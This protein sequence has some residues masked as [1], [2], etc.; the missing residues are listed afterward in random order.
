VFWKSSSQGWLGIDWGT[1]TIKFAQL[2]RTSAG[3]RLARKVLVRRSCPL[4]GE[5]PSLAQW[6]CDD[7]PMGILREGLFHRQGAAC[8]LP[9]YLADVRQFDLPETDAGTIGTLVMGELADVFGEQVSERVFDHW[10][11]SSTRQNRGSKHVQVL[12]L[13]QSLALEIA[14]TVS[15]AGVVCQAIDGL[16]FALARAIELA[17]GP[18]DRPKVTLDWGYTGANVCVL[19]GFTPLYTRTLRDCGLRRLAAALAE[20]LSISDIEVEE[21]L[22]TS[23]LPG[24][25]STSEVQ[26]LT[27][28]VAGDTIRVLT[29]QLEKT[30]AYV[31]NEWP[32]TV[33]EELWLFGGASGVRHIADYLTDKTGFRVRTWQLPGSTEEASLDAP[34]GLAAAMSSLAWES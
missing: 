7:F 22:S 25:S 27:A 26:E 15:K 20:N 33:T 32:G 13:P 31:D 2:E 5:E 3:M 23:G 9:S 6:T 1:R 12:S 28:E 34:F 8:L 14:Q 10:E 4:V 29:A 24:T 18:S 11:C 16:P 30:L 21:L 17:D 19:R